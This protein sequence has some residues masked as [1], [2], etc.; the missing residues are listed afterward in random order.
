MHKQIRG[1]VSPTRR[2]L[3]SRTIRRLPVKD[4]RRR[5]G[6]TKW[7]KTWIN[8]TLRVTN[9][10]HWWHPPVRFFPKHGWDV[11]GQMARYLEYFKPVFIAEKHKGYECIKSFFIEDTEEDIKRRLDKDILYWCKKN[12]TCRRQRKN[13]VRKDKQMYA[14]QARS[15]SKRI[16]YNDLQEFWREIL[17]NDVN[18]EQTAL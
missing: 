4:R 10:G 15:K 12:K 14:Q 11:K 18:I 1:V 16:T 3:M 9:G 2:T 6:Y 7:Y 5:R 17:D 8:P 13:A